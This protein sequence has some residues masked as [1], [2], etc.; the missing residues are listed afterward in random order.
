MTL[1]YTQVV[2]RR[3]VTCL[4]VDSCSPRAAP[5]SSVQI[6]KQRLGSQHCLK[7]HSIWVWGSGGLCIPVHTHGWGSQP[8]RGCQEPQ[9]K[10]SFCLLTYPSLAWARGTVGL[11]LSERATF[12]GQHF[13]HWEVGSLHFWA[14]ARKAAPKWG[15]KIP[16]PHVTSVCSKEKC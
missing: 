14:L 13:P 5:S 15:Q 1:G 12:R 11:W 16:S 9:D 8:L 3:H 10:G 4:W 6:K 2:W 7:P